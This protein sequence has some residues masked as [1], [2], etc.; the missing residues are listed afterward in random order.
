[1]FPVASNRIGG[2]RRLLWLPVDAPVPPG[3]CFSP[4]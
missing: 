1:M 4:L 3:A 2:W